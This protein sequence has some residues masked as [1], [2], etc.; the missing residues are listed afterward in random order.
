M[1]AS[2]YAELAALAEE[3]WGLVTTA[4]AE[5]IGIGRLQLSRL[6]SSSRLVRV[7]RGVYRIAGA[8][9]TEDEHVRATWL[10]LGGATLATTETGVSPIVAAGMTAAGVHRIGDFWPDEL[11]FI[12]P[13]RRGTRLPDV[14]LRVR[15]LSQREVVPVD[16]LPA[17]TVERTIADL[18]EMFT[19][20]SLVADALRDA[21][22][23]GKLTSRRRLAEYLEP[24]AGAHGRSD[25]RGEGFAQE[26][27][28]MTGVDPAVWTANV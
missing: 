17:L 26:L 14:R 20:L 11:D 18:V 2:D 25:H 10:A 12:V 6:A 21:I 15:Q 3:R 7:G 16:G 28:D 24:L 13:R 5:R 23:Q 22:F 9:E 1:Q 8:P 19:D 27:I 4:Q